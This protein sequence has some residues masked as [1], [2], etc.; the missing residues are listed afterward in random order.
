VF[1]R[2]TGR[3][4]GDDGEDDEVPDTELQATEVGS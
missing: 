4:F 3:S 1:L 2:L